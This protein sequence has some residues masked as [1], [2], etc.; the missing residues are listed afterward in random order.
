MLLLL[1][2][3]HAI[4]DLSQDLDQA[5]LEHAAT[6]NALELGVVE[7]HVFILFADPET[8]HDELDARISIRDQLLAYK[9]LRYDLDLHLGL[10][11]GFS[12]RTG[13]KPF[14][15]DRHLFGE[16]RHPVRL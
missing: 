8:L 10:L 3:M 7:V 13:S 1:A 15:D 12:L 16:G 5:L 4:F 14:V 9:Q 11:V 6:E 2:S